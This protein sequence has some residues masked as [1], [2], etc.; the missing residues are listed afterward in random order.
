MGARN[1]HY[2]SQWANEVG[3]NTKRNIHKGASDLAHLASLEF[4]GLGKNTIYKENTTTYKEEEQKLL[5]SS[6]QIQD[7]IK[8]LELKDETKA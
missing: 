8:E 6:K 5:E 7:L 4:L 3:K 1:R 2:K